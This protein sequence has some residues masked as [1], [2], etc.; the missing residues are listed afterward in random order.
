[1]GRVY[2]LPMADPCG[3]FTYS[4]LDLNTHAT[5]TGSLESADR[6]WFVRGMGVL[7]GVI[8]L[9][10]PLA[11]LLPSRAWA[12]ELRVLTSAEAAALL[13]MLASYLLW[14]HYRNEDPTAGLGAGFWKE[15]GAISDLPR[16]ERRFEPSL[17]HAQVE[18]TRQRWNEAISRAKS[19]EQA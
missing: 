7:T 15:V 2:Q 3:S 1:M 17:P 10:H 8:A 18:A 4:E 14:H 16:E 5:H 19:W 13:V 11:S 12:V 9:G 6:R